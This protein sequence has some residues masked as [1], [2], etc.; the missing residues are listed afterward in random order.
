MF[1]NV[2]N[3]RRED[4]P[5]PVIPSCAICQ[6]AFGAYHAEYR[7]EGAASIVCPKAPVPFNK[8]PVWQGESFG[9]AGAGGCTV[10]LEDR[11]LPQY[12]VNG[13]LAS[14]LT[15]WGKGDPDTPDYYFELSVF[16]QDG[17]GAYASAPLWRG[18]KLTGPDARGEYAAVLR[19]PQHP[20]SVPAFLRIVP[21]IPRG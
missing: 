5:W 15:T 11:K 7:V 17:S 14:C 20:M 3:L 13:W 9:V 6:P 19:N 10:I 8:L 21:F 1:L 16:G 4:G 12:K 2:K 18:R